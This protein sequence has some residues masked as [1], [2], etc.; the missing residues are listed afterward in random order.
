MQKLIGTAWLLKE[1]EGIS[2]KL[3]ST[4]INGEFILMPPKPESGGA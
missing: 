2:V 3:D 1:K 4:S